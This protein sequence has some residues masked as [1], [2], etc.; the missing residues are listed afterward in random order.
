METSQEGESQPE[1]LP[2][3]RETWA[4]WKMEAMRVLEASACFGKPKPVH[5]PAFSCQA[6][7]SD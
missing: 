2:K 6:G 5:T 4:V 3:S 7:K 1:F